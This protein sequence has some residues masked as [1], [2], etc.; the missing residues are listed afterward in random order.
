[1]DFSEALARIKKDEKLKRSGW[2]G[3]NQHI[4]LYRCSLAYMNDFIVIFTPDGKLTPWLA[5]QADLLAED[6][7]VTQ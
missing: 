6:W 1:M 7:E 4:R 3:K 5:S 2:N